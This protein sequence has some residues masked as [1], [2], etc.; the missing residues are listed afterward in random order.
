[1]TIVRP[2]NCTLNFA[3]P[4]AAL[5]RYLMIG[6][7]AGG[8]DVWDASMYAACASMENMT[9]ATAWS[10]WL[11]RRVILFSGGTTERVALPAI[12]SGLSGS[13]SF[14]CW[15]FLL[16]A[17]AAATPIGTCMESHVATYNNYWANLGGYEGKWEF[18]L[19]NGSQN[20][21]AIGPAYA[22]GVWVHLVGSRNVSADTVSVTVNGLVGYSAND[23]TASVPAYSAFGIGKGLHP[24]QPRNFTGYLADPMVF[25]DALPIAAITSLA[26]P[27][28]IFLEY[29]PGPLIL[30]P[31]D[32]Y[33]HSF[34]GI[35]I[36]PPTTNTPA[37]MAYY[38][39]RR[40]A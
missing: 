7:Q 29:G 2:D 32:L 30:P 11:S 38:R 39:R 9:P 20:P 36:A 10:R 5:V 6:N 1:M 19:F 22:T 18:A 24:S 15:A 12:T 14:A 23:N 31:D 28:N 34:P 27:D 21:R 13:F 33:W 37:I 3:H 26:R 40:C 16:V 4:D 8:V 35:T 25:M 17:P